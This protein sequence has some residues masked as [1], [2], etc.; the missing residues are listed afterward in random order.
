MSISDVIGYYNNIVKNT[1]IVLSSSWFIPSILCGSY[2]GLFYLK[3][4]VGEDVYTKEHKA[5]L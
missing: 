2:R 1:I 4:Q 5:I 3:T